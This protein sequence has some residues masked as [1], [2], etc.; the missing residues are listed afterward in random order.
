MGDICLIKGWSIGVLAFSVLQVGGDFFIQEKREFF[1]VPMLDGVQLLNLCL[2]LFERRSLAST[3][4]STMK[5]TVEVAALAKLIL[6]QYSPSSVQVD[7]CFPRANLMKPLHEAMVVR[8][9]DSLSS[10]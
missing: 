4:V 6:Y 1:A 7:N 5:R 2:S 10:L 3:T 9:W 8:N